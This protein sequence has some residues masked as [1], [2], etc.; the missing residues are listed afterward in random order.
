MRCTTT[1][2]PAGERRCSGTVEVV[3]RIGIMLGVAAPLAGADLLVK[4]S[5]PTEAWAY[6]ERS[7]TWLLLS[8][9]LFA[10]LVVIVRIT[11]VLVALAAG[12]LA[13]GLLGNSLSAAS[14]AMKVPNPLMIVGDRGAV[15]FNL[16]DVWVLTGILLLILVLGILLVRHRD[17]IRSPTEGAALAERLP[18]PSSTDSR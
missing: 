7:F 4:S 12:V 1:I 2:L 17:L 3:G 15:A 6:H 13:G 18:D 16:A 9:A 5:K 8:V 11:P 10:G 14:N